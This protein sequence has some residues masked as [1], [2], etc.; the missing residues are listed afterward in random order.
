MNSFYL[1]FPLLG[2]IDQL[3]RHVEE[4]FGGTS[5]I[6]AERR[7]SFPALNIGTTEKSVEILAFV[8]GVDPASLEVTND[9][10]VL[11][12]SGERKAMHLPEG[13]RR[14]AQE[15]FSGT[16]RRTIELPQNI[17][18]SNV[19]ARYLNGCLRIS[20]AK[21]EPSAPRSISIQ[22]GELS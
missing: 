13:S 6:R 22:H 18:A 3:H 19:T 4:L 16:F 8:P 2:E 20:V 1:D 5:S 10:G 21:E 17:D 9:K 11:A 12:L 7:G 15:R 14:Y